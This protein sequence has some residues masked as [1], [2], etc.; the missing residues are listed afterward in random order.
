MVLLRWG[1][2]LSVNAQQRVAAFGLCAA[3]LDSYSAGTS[4]APETPHAEPAP[5]DPALPI[6]QHGTA[7]LVKLFTK[8]AVPDLCAA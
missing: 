1:P 6:G 5:L 7:S 8:V 3:R 4:Y 2:G